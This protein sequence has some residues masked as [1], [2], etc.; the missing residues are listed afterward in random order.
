MVWECAFGPETPLTLDGSCVQ[1]WCYGAVAFRIF[2]SEGK[3]R[4]GE[5]DLTLILAKSSGAHLSQ[6]DLQTVRFTDSLLRTIY[7]GFLLLLKNRILAC[8][9]CAFIL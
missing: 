3:G 2:D 9:L 1:T 7:L 5:K 8:Y 6:S 4:I